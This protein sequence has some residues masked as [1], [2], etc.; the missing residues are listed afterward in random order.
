MLSLQQT[1]NNEQLYLTFINKSQLLK[2]FLSNSCRLIHA[3]YQWDLK[4][5]G[6]HSLVQTRLKSQKQRDISPFTL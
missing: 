1:N 6:Y 2:V 3:W 5:S 4:W